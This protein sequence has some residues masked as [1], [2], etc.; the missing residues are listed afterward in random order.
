MSAPLTPQEIYLLERY[1]SLEYF[2]AM[3]DHFAAMLKATHDALD[4]FMKRVPPDYRSL[5]TSQQPDVVWGERV[6]PNLQWVLD[7]LNK[8][9]IRIAHGIWTHWVLPAMWVLRLQRSAATIRGIGWLITTKR[10][11]RWSAELV[12]VPRPTS[13]PQPLETG[14]R[15][16]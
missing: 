2:G 8:A 13:A 9:Y 16:R 1:S 7:G 3:R 5:H 10:G 6:I 11:M 4:E 14:P 15:A 12:A